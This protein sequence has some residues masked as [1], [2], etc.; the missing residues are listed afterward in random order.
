M[1]SRPGS[2]PGKA[3]EKLAN[4]LLGP[5]GEDKRDGQTGE[6]QDSSY[7]EACWVLGFKPNASSVS[8]CP[9]LD[10]RIG[11]KKGYGRTMVPEGI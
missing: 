4:G 8:T 10:S 9:E 1:T 11:R 7:S 5:R 6:T 3:K 2:C